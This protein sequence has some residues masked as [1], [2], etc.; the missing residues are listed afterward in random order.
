METI[1]AI[2]VENE[3]QYSEYLNNMIE[4]YY[5]GII[6]LATCTTT[7]DSVEKIQAIKPQLVFLDIRLERKESGFEIL[8]LTRNVPYDVIFT[9]AYDA[10]AVK[11]FKFSAVDYILKPFGLDELKAAMDKYFS[12][13]LGI[14]AKSKEALLYNYRQTDIAMHKVGI[15]VEDGIDF[16]TVSEIIYC[17]ASGNYTEIYLTDKK[18]IVTSKN[19]G[20]IEDLL[21]GHIFFRV[22]NS[23]LV[24]L[25]HLKK[26]KKKSEGGILTLSDNQK[27][28]VAKR[29]KE[30]FFKTL[31]YLKIVL[32]K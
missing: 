15:P 10:Y 28:D 18:K 17:K 20:T 13:A 27:V 31:A 22:H 11:A 4:R 26:F 30:E 12:K 16:I 7:K 1:N 14:T 32:A 24:N 6:V 3:K 5:K 19:L 8:E 21:S 29:R 25:N 23:F 2:I 9:T